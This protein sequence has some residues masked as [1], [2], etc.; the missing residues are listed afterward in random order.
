M[1]HKNVTKHANTQFIQ[2]AKQDRP[3]AQDNMRIRG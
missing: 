3:R 1:G 2:K